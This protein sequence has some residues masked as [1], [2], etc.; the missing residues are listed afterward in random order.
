MQEY[1]DRKEDQEDILNFNQ[2]IK[3]S[4]GPFYPEL[5]WR[6]AFDVYNFMTDMKR[7]YVNNRW[8]SIR[9][10]ET[11]EVVGEI[12]FHSGSRI[13]DFVEVGWTVMPEKQGRGYATLAARKAF[14]VMF[15]T[16]NI[17]RIFANIATT[18]YNSQAVAKKLHL[19][20]EGTVRSRTLMKGVRYDD[21]IFSVLRREYDDWKSSF[22]Q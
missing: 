21:M 11:N 15:E 2:R 20:Y 14:E 10:T 8:F 12:Q 7:Q 22:D 4:I 6:S 17:N 9:L 5:F 1:L 19:T 3:D 16:T 13:N 18:N